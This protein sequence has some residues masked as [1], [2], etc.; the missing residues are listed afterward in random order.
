VFKNAL[1]TTGWMM[2]DVDAM[3]TYY[4]KRGSSLC[5]HHNLV[6]FYGKHYGRVLRVFFIP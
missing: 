5:V 2:Q 3:G 1:I 4:N 6:Y